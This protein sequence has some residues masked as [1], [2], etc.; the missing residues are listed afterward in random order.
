MQNRLAKY[1][2]GRGSQRFR[3]AQ[4]FDPMSTVLNAMAAEGGPIAPPSADT[5][6][7]RRLRVVGE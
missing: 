6:E 3:S 5:S 4:D 7:P 1:K 2:I